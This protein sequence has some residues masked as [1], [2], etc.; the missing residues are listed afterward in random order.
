MIL[1]VFRA[2]ALSMLRDRGALGMVFALPP[3][4]FVVFATAFS[5]AGGTGLRLD[6]AYHDNNAGPA[7]AALL[8]DI[9]RSTLAAR[10]R[11]VA[12]DAEV[13]DL[14]RRGAADAGLLL[15]GPGEAQPGAPVSVIVDPSK[16]MA[17][18]VLVGM[19]Q[20]SL[21]TAR[22]GIAATT[23]ENN[24]GV[25]VENV[26][27]GT[28]RSIT[29]AYYAGGV[30]ILFLLFSAVQSAMTLIEERASG[31]LDRVLAGPGGATHIV[32]GK[33]AFLVLQGLVQCGL[34]FVVAWRG[35]DVDLTGR[36]LPWLATTFLAASTAGALALALTTVCRTRQQAQAASTFLI[37]LMSAVGG[38]MAPRFTMPAWMQ[39][40]GWLTP[41]A[42]V[43]EAY[44]DTL[45]R[46]EPAAAVLHTWLALAGVT[47]A[48][49]AFAVVAVRRLAY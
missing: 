31:T 47:A 1:A 46:G 27:P 6:I 21:M 38:S 28:T 29:A 41:N 32:L 18:P 48:G 36:P 33:F 43:I 34:V 42:W 14:V 30:A 11:E 44:Q 39:D 15:A 19:V 35:Y 23:S 24:G 17:T 45:W 16:A 7:S 13:R 12:S 8:H 40:V 49:L 5:T 22:A 4:I 10:L 26:V 3:L 9:G 2:M 25:T 20:R 37:M